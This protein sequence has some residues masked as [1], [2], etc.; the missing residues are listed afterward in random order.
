MALTMGPMEILPSWFFFLTWIE[1]W[2]FYIP[3]RNYQVFEYGRINTHKLLIFLIKKASWYQPFVQNLNINMYCD[4]RR[5]KHPRAIL[6]AVFMTLV[7]SWGLI[8]LLNSSDQTTHYFLFSFLIQYLLKAPSEVSI[9]VADTGKRNGHMVWD[10]YYGY[11]NKTTKCGID[12][13]CH[14]QCP[15]LSW[16]FRTLPS[17]AQMPSA[18]S[19][20]IKRLQSTNRNKT[21]PCVN[22]GKDWLDHSFLFPGLVWSGKGFHFGCDH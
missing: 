4:W 12:A 1:T 9:F 11:D 17:C 7:R 20:H 3:F 13:R 8:A 10:P 14:G 2:S 16:S 6:L 5:W 19:R 18:P 15:S 21:R 22:F